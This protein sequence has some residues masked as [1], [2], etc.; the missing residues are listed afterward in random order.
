MTRIF[1]VCATAAAIGLVAAPQAVAR[2]EVAAGVIGGLALGAILSEA[3]T[4]QRPYGPEYA[5][6]YAPG[7]AYAVPRGEVCV[8]QQEVWSPRAQAYIIRNVRV[9]CY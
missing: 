3:A 8:Q 2:N 4:P 5:P 6:V 7:P 9:P 1:V